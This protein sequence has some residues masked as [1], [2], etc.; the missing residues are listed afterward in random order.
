MAR[1]EDPYNIGA[2]HRA[3][4]KALA[5]SEISRTREREIYPQDGVSE[6]P[7]DGT[8]KLV[9]GRIYNYRK[10]LVIKS[11][12]DNKATG[13]QIKTEGNYF[14]LTATFPTVDAANLAANSI[15]AIISGADTISGLF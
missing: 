13:A 9:I 11:L 5:T 15:R 8:V 1:R 7:L 3:A 4:R 2:G 12:K 6:S 10:E 14:N